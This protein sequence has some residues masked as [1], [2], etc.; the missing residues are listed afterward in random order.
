MKLTLTFPFAWVALWGYGFPRLLLLVWPPL[1]EV[2]LVVP[3]AVRTLP[4]LLFT[5]RS[6]SLSRSSQFALSRSH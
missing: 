3:L 5:L 2:E 4:F 6:L 1:H